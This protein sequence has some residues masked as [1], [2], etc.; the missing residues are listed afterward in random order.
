M[1]DARESRARDLVVED[2]H[3]RVLAYEHLIAGT[4]MTAFTVSS[5]VYLVSCTR[6]RRRS[7]LPR[8]RVRC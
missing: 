8:W 6:A 7:C 4:K 3:V 5:V 1:L 2:R